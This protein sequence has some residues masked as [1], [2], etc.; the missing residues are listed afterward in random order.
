LIRIKNQASRGSL[1]NILL[2]LALSCS[3]ARSVGPTNLFRLTAAL[4]QRSLTL[5]LKQRLGTSILQAIRLFR[6]R[7]L[8]LTIFLQRRPRQPLFKCSGTQP[9]VV[10]GLWVAKAKVWDSITGIH[11]VSRPLKVQ[12]ELCLSVKNDWQCPDLLGVH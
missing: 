2:S 12:K 5:Y 7:R 9:V 1:S 8:I 11:L 3:Q 6:I 10:V 4:Y